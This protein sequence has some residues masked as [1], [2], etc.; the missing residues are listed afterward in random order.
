MSFKTT[1]AGGLTASRFLPLIKL[2]IRRINT[3]IPPP[4]MGSQYYLLDFSFL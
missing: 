2:A 4:A 1:K 3:P